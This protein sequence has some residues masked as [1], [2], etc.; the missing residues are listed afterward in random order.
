SKL[1]V[2]SLDGVVVGSLEHGFVVR[3]NLSGEEIRVGTVLPGWAIRLLPGDRVRVFGGY[4][5]P[6]EWLSAW[7]MRHDES[8]QWVGVRINP[9][10]KSDPAE[11]RPWPLPLVGPP[12]GT[13]NA[14][15]RLAD[16]LAA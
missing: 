12:P 3:S 5:E 16:H 11:K 6:G 9:D 13:P 8:G 7:A 15:R 10:D 4:G 2:A 1:M 14:L